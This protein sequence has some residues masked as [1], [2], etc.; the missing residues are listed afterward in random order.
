M[1]TSQNESSVEGSVEEID[2]AAIEPQN[3]KEIIVYDVIE[4][5]KVAEGDD[6]VNQAKS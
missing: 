2:K 3:E 1:V 5:D 6:V 4:G